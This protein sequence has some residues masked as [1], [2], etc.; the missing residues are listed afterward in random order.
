MLQPTYLSN[1]AVR[2]ERIN[3]FTSPRTRISKLSPDGEI[4]RCAWGEL[5]VKACRDWGMLK[6]A[7]GCQELPAITSNQERC[8]EQIPSHTS[9]RN[10]PCCHTLVSDF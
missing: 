3:T 6:E 8:M 10:Q 7:T 2:I 4:Q 9:R 1:G 5:H